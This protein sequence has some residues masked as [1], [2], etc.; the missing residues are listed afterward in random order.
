MNLGESMPMGTT[1]EATFE[2]EAIESPVL[3]DGTNKSLNRSTFPFLFRGIK[4]NKPS[5]CLRIQDAEGN[6]P[7]WD[8]AGYLA[9]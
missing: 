6:L 2:P 3:R 7:A 1:K 8:W 9:D 4:T 5:Q